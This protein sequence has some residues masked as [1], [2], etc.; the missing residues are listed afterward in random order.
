MMKNTTITTL[1]AC[2]LGVA[3]ATA[4]NT[5]SAFTAPA[6]FVTHTLRAGQFN[7]I[8][9][10]LHE[11][12]VVSGQLDSVN[13]TTLG[14]NDV[15]F[16]TAL[17]DGTTYILEITNATIPERIGTIQEVTSWTANT[18]E[19][20]DDLGAEGLV[21]GDSYTIRPAVTIQEVF[22][23]PPSLT[24]NASSGSSDIIWLPNG[25][26]GFTRYFFRTPLSGNSS[27]F[28]ADTNTEVTSGIPIIFT[29]G[30]LVQ[31]QDSSPNVDLVVTGTVKTNQIS[32]AVFEGFN[33]VSNVYPVGSTLQNSGLAD[34]LSSTASSVSSDVVW[35]PAANGSFVRY[36][37][38]TTLSGNSSWFN[39]DT[40]TEVTEDINLTSAFYIQRAN[41]DAANILITPPENYENL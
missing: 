9:L 6:G 14:D 2:L 19:T 20:G 12:V 11:A 16:T 29:D 34:G 5:Q 4:Q 13:G 30:I 31:L 23:T 21:A 38:R 17:T 1:A 7:L 35:I 24:S 32:V 15:D 36:F 37:Y 39:A 18:F 33:L 41:D 25:S 10:T 28:N 3:G 26:G 22:G 8:G 27:W 40:N